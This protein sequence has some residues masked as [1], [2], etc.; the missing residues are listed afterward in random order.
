MSRNQIRS[1]IVV[2]AALLLVALAA[3]PAAARPDPGQGAPSTAVHQ[4]KCGLPPSQAFRCDE[5]AGN[6]SS[7]PAW[8]GYTDDYPAGASAALL[9]GEPRSPA[10]LPGDLRAR[11]D[12]RLAARPARPVLV[13]KSVVPV[14]DNGVQPLYVGLGVVAGMAGA[15]AVG[16]VLTRRR[17][18]PARA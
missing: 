12:E 4:A 11:A 16:F 2:P 5:H 8:A 17:V 6:R 15:S 18:R 7:A 1:P 14:D 13:R 3:G 9:P 10:L